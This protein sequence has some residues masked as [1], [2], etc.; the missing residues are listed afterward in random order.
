MNTVGWQER[1]GWHPGHVRK[2]KKIDVARNSSFNAGPQ[3]LVAYCW[4]LLATE[5]LQQRRWNIEPGTQQQYLQEMERRAAWETVGKKQLFSQPGA[6]GINNLGSG[7]WNRSG[8]GVLVTQG[9]KEPKCQWRRH[10]ACPLACSSH[11]LFLPMHCW[12]PT[13]GAFWP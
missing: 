6:T 1:R 10:W 12:G 3:M 7:I 11:C 2:G 8:L 4:L 13:L 9:E 5:M